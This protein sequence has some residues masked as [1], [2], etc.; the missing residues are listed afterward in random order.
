MMEMEMVAEGYYGT[1]Y[2]HR[3]NKRGP[4]VE[5]PIMEYVYGVLYN[6]RSPRVTLP[7]L[8]DSFS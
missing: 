6:G 8:A 3:I 1:K 2:I 5:M 4:K 7:A